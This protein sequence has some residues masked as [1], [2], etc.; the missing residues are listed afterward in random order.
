MKRSM[1]NS[2]ALCFAAKALLLLAG[3][4]ALTAAGAYLF[5]RTVNWRAWQDPRA[6]ILWEGIDPDASIVIIG[7]SAFVSGYADREDQTLWKVLEKQT[8][9]RVFNGALDGA[10]PPDFVS[11]AR[12]LAQ[13]PGTG[14]VVVLDI[15]PTRFLQS[16]APN[17]DSGNY[18]TEFGRRVG[19]APTGWIAVA[20]MEPLRTLDV[21]ILA[22]LVKRKR[23][24]ATDEYRDTLWYEDARARVKFN[25]FEQ[26]WLPGGALKD[27]SWLLQVQS[28]LA[29]RGYQLLIVLMPANADLIRAYARWHSASEYESRMN[30]AHSAVSEYLSQ[31]H[32]CHIDAYGQFRSA[33]FADLVHVNV[34]GDDHLAKLIAGYLSARHPAC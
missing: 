30:Y 24:F 17:Q 5:D 4:Y 15:I 16:R 31:N 33:E 23:F 9:R 7:D 32:I 22:N 34:R 3:F 8:G 12:M 21:N 2:P 1:M 20:L 18:P 10:E 6:R 26:Y 11:V 19:G 27:P 13:H 28:L 25:A 29:A 14:K